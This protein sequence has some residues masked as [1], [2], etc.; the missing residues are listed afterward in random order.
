MTI[1]NITTKN[2]VFLAPMAGVTDS[3]FRAICVEFGAGYCTTEMVSSKG[4]YYKDK[5]TAELMRITDGEKPCAIQIFGS[6]P[7]I[8]AYAAERCL[9]FGA[10]A[11]DINMGCPTPKIVNNGDGSALAKNIPLAAEIAREVKRA[12]DIPVTVKIRAGWSADS[13][14]AVDMAKALEQAGIDAIALHART[15]EQF[16]SGTADWSLIKAVKSAV[17]IP[18]IGNG[19]IFKAE[20]AAAMFERTGCDAVMVGRGAC[21]NPFIFREI[22]EFLEYGRVITETTP[23]ERIETALSHT[24]AIVAD[25]GEYRAIREARKHIAWYIKGMCGASKLKTEIFKAETFSDVKALL[26]DF[27]A[28]AE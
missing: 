3:V 18:V 23:Q 24:A 11:V 27:A 25:K 16:Y 1:G 10:A 13:I 9:E 17:S 28:H 14:N 8:M 26:E 15:R 7:K 22:A 21:G 12:V 2:N 4:L 19:D 5:K 6:D 20:D